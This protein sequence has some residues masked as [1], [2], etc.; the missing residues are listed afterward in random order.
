MILHFSFLSVSVCFGI[1]ATIRT[2]REI[3]CVPYAEFFLLAI[4]F[5]AYCC[6]WCYYIET[7]NFSFIDF[8]IIISE[9]YYL[10]KNGLVSFNL[11]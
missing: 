4:V 1:G 11:L 5:V 3:Q 2:R 6:Y 10:F 7:F 8:L 9:N